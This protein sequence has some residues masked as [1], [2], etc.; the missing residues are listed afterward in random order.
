V[1]VQAASGGSGGSGG[2][3][4]SSSAGN[5]SV[6]GPGAGAAATKGAGAGK[7]KKKRKPAICSSKR[8]FVIRIRTHHAHLVSATITVNGKLVKTLRGKRITAPVDLRGLPRGG[9]TVRIRVRAADGRVFTGKRVYHTC[10]PR[11]SKRTIPL[12]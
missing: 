1:T 9:F 11:K 4:A 6:S 12:L 5:V 2:D 7:H 3:S 8:R 10:A